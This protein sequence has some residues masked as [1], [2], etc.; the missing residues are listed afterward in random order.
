MDLPID[1][2]C[3]ISELVDLGT[4]FLL[5]E[6]LPNH[7]LRS[8]ISSR[9]PDKLY[10]L[11]IGGPSQWKL[12]FRTSKAF[13][14]HLRK[15]KFAKQRDYGSCLIEDDL[16]S[17]EV[18]AYLDGK[19]TRV[20]FEY[21]QRYCPDP[22]TGDESRRLLENPPP[23]ICLKEYTPSNSKRKNVHGTTSAEVR[24]STEE[25]P[26]VILRYRRLEGSTTWGDFPSGCTCTSMLE[27]C[28][29]GYKF[30][31]WSWSCKSLPKKWF[32][33][34]G[35]HILQVHANVGEKDKY[36]RSRSTALDAIE[37]G[38][39]PG[40]K[41]DDPGLILGRFMFSF[42]DVW[43]PSPEMRKQCALR[44]NVNR[45]DDDEIWRDDFWM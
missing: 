43:I 2:W 25:G 30:G 7:D 9:V 33:E 34:M 37:F 20:N 16:I 44:P 11:V 23:L 17:R 5:Y 24:L 31:A 26:M 35:L 13:E 29:I 41:E 1:I 12:S 21:L 27:I 10:A 22:N 32:E 4:L 19:R 36:S 28:G 42:I 45:A 38:T 15:A 14:I 6:A 39:W 40:I 8:Y 18:K 3:N